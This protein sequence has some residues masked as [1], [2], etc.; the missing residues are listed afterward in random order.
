[1][2]LVCRVARF[3]IPLDGT[4]SG[5]LETVLDL[6]CTVGAGSGVVFH[7]SGL[8]GQGAS[9]CLRMWRPMAMQFLQ[10]AHQDRP[11][12]ETCQ[13]LARG[14]LCAIRALLCG[15]ARGELMK[16]TVSFVIAEN[17][18]FELTICVSFKP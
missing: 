15:E 16:T 7:Q 2:R 6:R 17:V 12:G 3:R 11:T 8:P 9:L 10:L 1:M 4:T 18:F 14:G 5:Q 13:E